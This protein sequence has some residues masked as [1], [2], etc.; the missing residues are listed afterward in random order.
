MRSIRRALILAAGIG[1]AACSKPEPPPERTEP[2]PANP[3]EAAQPAPKIH[4]ALSKESRVDVSLRARDAKLTGEIRVV[5]G[6]LEVDLMRLD[7]TRG[8][9]RVDVGSILMGAGDEGAGEKTETDRDQTSEARNWLD[10]GSNQ[11]ESVRARKRWAEFT[12]SEIPEVSA[13]AAHEGKVTRRGRAAPLI[14][15]PG[16][17]AGDAGGE[18]AAAVSEIR[19]VALVAVG[20]LTFHGFRVEHRAR[21]RAEF[22]Y[23]ATATATTTPTR[24]VV[25]T[26]SPLIVPLAAHDIKPRD[27]SGTF[28]A[29]GTKLLGTKVGRDA[30]VSLRLVA[31]PL[32]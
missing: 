1:L 20:A 24:V 32:R 25:E 11:P 13:E 10:L 19:R 5:E 17:D 22:H 3:P 9:V 29:E 8:T 28:V 26:R 7:R 12:I 14:D 15:S 27:A 31:T 30:R 16:E 21:L 6:Q 23:P 2:W 18:G 4:Y